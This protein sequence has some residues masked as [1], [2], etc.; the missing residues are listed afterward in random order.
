MK[1][2]YKYGIFEKKGWKPILLFH[3]KEEAEAMLRRCPK[4]LCEVREILY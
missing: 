2:Y 1:K 4:G 3:T